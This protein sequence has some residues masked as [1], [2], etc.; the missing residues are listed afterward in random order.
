[1]ADPAVTGQDVPSR[2]P[3]ARRQPPGFRSAE[4][5]PERH[6]EVSSLWFLSLDKQRKEP[7]PVARQQTVALRSQ[8]AE[9]ASRNGPNGDQSR[10]S[11]P[12]YSVRPKTSS[13]TQAPSSRH[14]LTQVVPPSPARRE[15]DMAS[16]RASV[17]FGEPID[18]LEQRAQRAGLGRGM[19]GV[20]D[21]MKLGARPGARQ[22]P[23]R[24]HGAD[25]VVATLHDGARDIGLSLI[26]ISEPTRPY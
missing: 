15:R 25:D 18:G 10:R 24:A 1:M 23:G 14:L 8:G 19:P 3:R 13:P 22:L 12:P 9:P 5:G 11:V 20:R 16:L 6:L 26:H 4:G 2:R 21:D 17:D 7:A